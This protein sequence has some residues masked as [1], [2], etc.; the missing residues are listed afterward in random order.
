MTTFWW[1]KFLFDYF[2]V[3]CAPVPLLPEGRSWD[4]TAFILPASN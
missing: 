4:G 3:V 2:L 1:C